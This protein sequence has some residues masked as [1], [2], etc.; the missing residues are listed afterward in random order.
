MAVSISSNLL[1]NSARASSVQENKSSF[2]SRYMPHS[3]LHFF[4]FQNSADE[5]VLVPEF[6]LAKSLLPPWGMQLHP[7][8]ARCLRSHDFSRIPFLVPEIAHRL[9][10]LVITS[11][12]FEQ[13]PLSVRILPMKSCLL[14]PSPLCNHN[15]C[16]SH[17]VKEK[18]SGWD[19]ESCM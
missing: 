18:Q 1:L 13:D 3:W 16:Q 6:C 2:K 7:C 11:W 12:S 9:C 15:R 4:K 19:P 14:Y 17:I 10:P 5:T 8:A